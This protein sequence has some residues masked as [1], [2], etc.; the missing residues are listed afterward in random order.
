MRI[1]ITCCLDRANESNKMFKYYMALLIISR[2]EKIHLMF[3]QGLKSWM[4]LYIEF[5]KP[6]ASMESRH[7][8]TR[9]KNILSCP[10]MPRIYARSRLYEF[11]VC[12]TTY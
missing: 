4:S 5:I 7:F 9:Q 8:R 11:G 12:T 1:A 2:K 3:R 6:G 10:K